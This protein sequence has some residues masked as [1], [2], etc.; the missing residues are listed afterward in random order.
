ML[1]GS[2][3]PLDNH[4]LLAANALAL[5]VMAAAFGLAGQGRT[6]EPYWRSWLVANLVLAVALGVYMVEASLPDVLAVTAANTLLLAGFGLRWR[7]ARQ[8]GGRSAGL[9]L[10]LAPTG[11]FLGLCLMP[12]V[13]GSY[14]VVYTVVN[15]LLTGLGLAAAYEFWRDRGNG[16]PS[17]YGLVIVYAAMAVSFGIRVGQGLM[18]GG[19]MPRHL[20]DDL[21]LILHLTIGLFHIIGGG[22][23]ALSVAH[24]RTAAQLRDAAMRDPLTKLLN[25]GAFEQQVRRKLADTAN[26]D[27][28]LVYF[29]IDNFK[30]VNDRFGHAAGDE[31]IRRCAR[32]CK[33]TLRAGDVV[34]RIGGEEFA[35]ILANVTAEQALA[36]TERIRLQVSQAKLSTGSGAHFGITVSA[37]IC[38]GCG[39]DDFDRLLQ[40]ADRGL[41][42]AKRLGRNR[43]E[44]LAA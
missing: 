24:E 36:V 13:F 11:L 29:D 17:R 33:E 6:D 30:S 21:M 41:Y 27:F 44:Q 7:A 20:P 25:R 34:A 15:I 39:A 4:T 3:M 10:A 18:A 26:R 43:V 35:A 5:L 16:L 14:G 9:A 1:R 37:G 38:H 32:I 40:V 31:A 23:F 22:A 28:A 12:W 42:K 2:L 19:D 8:F